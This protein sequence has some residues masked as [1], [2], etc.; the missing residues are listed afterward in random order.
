MDKTDVAEGLNLLEFKFPEVTKLDMAFPTFRTDPELLA[1]AKRRGFY[2]GSGPYNDLASTLFF[3]GGKVKFL[4][5]VPE[6]FQKRAWAYVRS[7]MGSFAP[8]HEDKDAIC[9]LILSEIVHPKLATE[10]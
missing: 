3:K 8:S 7:F 6:D 4:D 2:N 10:D 9:A 1:E 5:G